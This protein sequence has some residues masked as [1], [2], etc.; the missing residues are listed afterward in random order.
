VRRLVTGAIALGLVLLGL[1][2]AG[3]P[4]ALGAKAGRNGRIAVRRYLN[5]AQT[6]GA[7]FT[8]RPD[9][10]GLREV[11]RPRRGNV[12]D[13]PH[14]S[15]NGRWILYQVENRNG[16]RLFKIRPNGSSRKYLSPAAPAS[17]RRA[18]AAMVTP[19]GSREESGSPCSASR[20]GL[21]LTI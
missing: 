4:A 16:S 13:E 9:G 12:T 2:V 6:R 5:K 18:D 17:T 21:G 1:G 15:P 7:P 11:T 8:I 3:A 10:T 20:V 14:W 19:P